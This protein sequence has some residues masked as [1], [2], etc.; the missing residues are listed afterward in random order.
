[1]KKTIILGIIIL[2]GILLILFTVF[3]IAN[4]NLSKEEFVSLM[5][6]FK[7][8]SNVKIESKSLT[9]YVKDEYMLSIRSDGLYT[10][11]NEKT[12]ECISYLPDLKM[13]Q[14]INYSDDISGLENAEY[15]FIGYE[16]YNG[17]KCAVG[18][19]K[20]NE[21]DLT[22]K[23]WLDEER[24]TYLKIVNTGIDSSG[25]QYENVDEYVATYDIVTD[26]DVKKPDLTEYTM[27]SE[28]TKSDEEMITNI[29][30]N[31]DSS[32]Q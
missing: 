13:Y 1:M 6:D 25:S 3:S 15:K 12:R 21:L 30:I 22:T 8:V 31:D 2:I 14:L 27:I 19:F 26:E 16:N 32:I 20:F 9:K 17:T 18:E 4:K 24:G 5:G 11:G 28:D 10:W 29:T 7:Q 23:I